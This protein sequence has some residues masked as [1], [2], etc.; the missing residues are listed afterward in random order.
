MLKM[1]GLRIDRSG[2]RYIRTFEEKGQVSFNGKVIGD[3]FTQ[4][5][6]HGIQVSNKVLICF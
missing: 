4:C 6:F 2:G 1:N 3:I 5:A